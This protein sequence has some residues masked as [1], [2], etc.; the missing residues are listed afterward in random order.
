MTSG[1]VLATQDAK[2]AAN[3]L[4]QLTRQ[5][6]DEINKVIVQGDKLADPNQWDGQKAGQWRGQWSSDKGKLK[7]SV[8]QL[9]TL[10][11]RAKQVVEAIF[12]AG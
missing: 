9:D 1:R 7:Q 11:Q 8:E 6:Q 2:A 4:L 12:A 3:Q 10:E 5:L